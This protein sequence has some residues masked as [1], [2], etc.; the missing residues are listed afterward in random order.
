MIIRVMNEEKANYCDDLLTKLILDER[1]YDE[2]I[3]PNVHVKDYFKNVIKD[4]KNILLCYEEDNSILGYIYLKYNNGEYIIDGLYVEKEY[5]NKGIAKKLINEGLNIL[6]EKS[7]K[8]VNIN[9]L[10]DNEIA[11]NLYKELG[12]NEFKVNLRKEI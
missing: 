7:I 9:V 8:Y 1:Q 10:R 11:Y 12:F 4:D 5:R 6:K 3:D 2:S